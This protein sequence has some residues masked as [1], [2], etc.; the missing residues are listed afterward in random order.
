MPGKGMPGACQICRFGE[1][2]KSCLLV[3]LGS[4]FSGLI[5]N[6]T[7]EYSRDP[8]SQAFDSIWF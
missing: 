2:R 6:G 3:S 4:L 7:L 8:K 5:C 1:T